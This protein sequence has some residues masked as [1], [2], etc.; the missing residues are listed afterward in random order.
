MIVAGY[1]HKHSGPAAAHDRIRGGPAVARHHPRCHG[2]N[3]WRR[4][5]CRPKPGPSPSKRSSGILSR[6]TV[7]LL[8]RLEGQPAGDVLVRAL[9]RVEKFVTRQVEHARA[10]PTRKGWTVAR[11][12]AG[13]RAMIL[14]PAPSQVGPPG[15]IGPGSRDMRDWE[16]N[17]NARRCVTCLPL[18]ERATG[19]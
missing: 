5:S 10:Y 1:V 12:G 7:F 8:R 17:P 15:K 9:A 4:G 2:G 6:S 16:M 19:C 3:A 18:T 13:R 14:G 11:V